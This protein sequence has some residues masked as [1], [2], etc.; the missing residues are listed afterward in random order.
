MPGPNYIDSIQN[1]FR[2]YSGIDEKSA[3]ET[4][5][6]LRTIIST[7]KYPL[8]RLGNTNATE[9]AKVLE[10]SY[11]AMNIAFIVEWSRF[12]ELAGVNLYEV[13]NA[14]RMRPTHSNMMFP[15]IGVGGYCLTKDPLLA[16]WS[17]QNLFDTD[18]PLI[19]SEKSV[20]INDQMPLF[21]FNYLKES[22]KEN[23][24]G[25]RILLLGISYR[26][27]VADTRY[28]PVE[29]FYDYLISEHAQVTLHDPFVDQWEEK[30]KTISSDLKKMIEEEIEILIFCTNH[31]E[32]INN[33]DLIKSI[34][35]KKQLF[36]LD[37]IGVLNEKEI[38]LL[39]QKHI[40]KVVGRGD[41]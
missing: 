26:S 29:P 1:F 30:S 7:E 25:K 13:V 4:E 10:N 40:V 19:Q 23:L 9:M 6:F 27:N 11:R 12:A 3:I 32:Y 34:M 24:D 31:S 20:Q 38:N 21:A 36:I 37:T 17:K 5:Y 39:K 33:E 22:F 14:I 8:T 41:L 35:S 2:V 16:S 18:S 15:G 28:T